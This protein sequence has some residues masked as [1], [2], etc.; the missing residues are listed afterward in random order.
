MRKK[1]YVN[2]TLEVDPKEML[3]KKFKKIK[4]VKK[5]CYVKWNWDLELSDKEVEEWDEKK[6]V[7]TVNLKPK[8]IDDGIQTDE[9]KKSSDTIDWDK[10]TDELV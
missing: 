3:E 8:F 7:K 6:F 5:V 2:V 9:W 10:P 4:W 1:Y